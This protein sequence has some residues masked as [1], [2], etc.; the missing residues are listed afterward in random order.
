MLTRR[1]SV[2]RPLAVGILLATNTFCGEDN[3]ALATRPSALRAIA[4]SVAPPSAGWTCSAAA[5]TVGQGDVA[6]ICRSSAG[7]KTV[8][9]LVAADSIRM[10]SVWWSVEGVRIDTVFDSLVAA[11]TARRGNGR[12]VCPAPDAAKALRWQDQAAAFT[13]SQ[14]R[15]QQAVS[16]SWVLRP[17]ADPCPYPG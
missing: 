4:D 12:P 11:A 13:I 10:V 15:V 5:T 3:Q 1:R 17:G 14:R 6:K 16:L 7:A 8:D 9:V 2:L